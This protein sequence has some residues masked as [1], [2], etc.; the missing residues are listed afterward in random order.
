MIHIPRSYHITSCVNVI[1]TCSS[2]NT[3][4]VDYKLN[5]QIHCVQTNCLHRELELVGSSDP[6]SSA[7]QAAG[8]EEG[9]IDCSLRS[10]QL[11]RLLK[12]HVQP[13]TLT[14]SSPS[15]VS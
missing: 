9:E 10:S 13:S 15:E 7:Q 11:A 6:K 14:L 2:N 5:P 12:Q 1:M 3:G 4:L 8:E